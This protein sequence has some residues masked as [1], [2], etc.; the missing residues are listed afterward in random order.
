MED[1]MIPK[2]L[3]RKPQSLLSETRSTPTK[4]QVEESM[5]LDFDGPFEDDPGEIMN[6]MFSENTPRTHK[7]FTAINDLDPGKD[8]DTQERLVKITQ[9]LRSLTAYRP[10][11]L[12]VPD[13]DARIDHLAS[14]FPN[15]ERVTRS[16]IGVHARLLA[17]G[18]EHRMPPVLLL[19]PP[20][21]GKTVYA[22]AAGELLSAPILRLDF[23]SENSPSGLAGSSTF[24]SNSSPGR[25]FNILAFG[26]DRDPVANPIVFV[27]EM[28]KAS[29]NA[30]Y[31]ITTPLLRL[32]EKASAKK[33]IDQSVPHVVLDTSQVRWI[34]TA[35]S[36]EG[37]SEPLLSRLVI[38]NIESPTPDQAKRIAQVIANK[39]VTE[40]GVSGFYSR[41]TEKIL[42]ECALMTPREV[43]IRVEIAIGLAITQDL[44]CITQEVW[45][46]SAVDEEPH[47]KR[48]GAIGFI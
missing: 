26:E 34:L 11:C 25:L 3:A 39:T 23:A 28:D 12:P 44:D 22:E 46:E 43:R 35:N 48:R 20:G 38:F 8:K 10:V 17:R 42:A 36:I 16:I 45:R 40:F 2:A 14:T 30:Q 29:K 13:L 6:R 32:L 31:D 5:R 33:F 15:F 21:V 27:D 24:W 9:R 18:I 37:V 7:V 19:G 47:Q 4:A 41:L 1:E